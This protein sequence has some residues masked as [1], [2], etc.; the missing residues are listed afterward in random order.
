MATKIGILGSGMVGE[1]L[2][3]GFKKYDFQ[4]QR[5]SRGQFAEIAAWAD[6]IV[7]AVKGLVA[8]AALTLAER[9][10]LAE[11]IVIDATNPIDESQPQDGVLRF[12]TTLDRSL[13]EELQ[14]KF[15]Q[16]KFVKAFNSVGSAH[17]VDPS[18][19]GIKP[20]MFICGN[21][22][23]AK[24]QVSSILEQFGWETEDMGTAKAARAIEPL[25]MLWC[26]PGFRDNQWNHAFKLL[27]KK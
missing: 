18:F 3:Q 25:C 2:E 6:V 23:H 17:M 22:S 13:M 1:A 12:F 11:K 9:E 27:K 16:T 21:D 26:I 10:N 8:E 19:D 7:L 14:E 5:G 24:N 4:V 15:P 20:T